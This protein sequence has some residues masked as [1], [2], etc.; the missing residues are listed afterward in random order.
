MNKATTTRTLSTS[1]QL[2]HDLLLA[3][4]CGFFYR[5]DLLCLMRALWI[6]YR[7]CHAISRVRE[8]VRAGAAS[9]GLHHVDILC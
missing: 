4:A 8:S 2:H 7:Q 1:E 9:D 6:V 3:T 5:N